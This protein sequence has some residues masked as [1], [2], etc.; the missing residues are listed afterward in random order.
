MSERSAF[1]KIHVEESETGDLGGVL[2]Q[3]N[4]PPAVVTFVRENKRLVQICIAAVVIIVVAWSLYNSY[5]HKKIEEGS[6]ALSV[7][8]DI[9]DT[10]AKIDQLKSV[11]SKYPR[12]SS[13]VWAKINA[14][15]E[16][17]KTDQKDEALTMYQDVLADIDE[18]SP[19]YPLVTL[20]LA[21]GQEV[22]GNY[23]EAAAEF[24]KVKNIEGYQDAGYF[25]L[26]RIS[27]AQGDNQ[28]ALEIYEE[29]LTTLMNVAEMN[30]K[31]LVEEKIARLRAVM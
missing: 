3:L 16:M 12:T 29:Y 31:S 11:S 6:S 9:E 23:T 26:A 5:R 10:Q 24:E 1:E 4:L 30:Q 28:K 22:I 17:I 19:L 21:Q 25:G 18:S 20:S 7:A 15:H 8:V 14:A 2:E 27:E 13:A